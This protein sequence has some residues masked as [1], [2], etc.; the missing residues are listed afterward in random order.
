VLHFSSDLG[1]FD[2]SVAEMWRVLAPDG[3]FFARLASNIGLEATVGG[4]GRRVRLPDGSERFI[5]D[6]A[7]LLERTQRLGGELLDP[8][9]TTNVQQRRCMTTWCVRKAAA[10]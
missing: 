3:L 6:E 7:M 5:V 2:R 4:A 10:L 9:K 8:I 1:Q